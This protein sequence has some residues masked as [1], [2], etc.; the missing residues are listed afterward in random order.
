MACGWIIN[1]Q[2]VVFEGVKSKDSLNM[3][4]SDQHELTDVHWDLHILKHPY[5]EMHK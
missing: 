2:T 1:N 3:I 4:K 5:R